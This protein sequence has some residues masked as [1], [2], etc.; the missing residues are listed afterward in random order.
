MNACQLPIETK[1]IT[2]VVLINV[3]GERKQ[4]NYGS[5]K[6]ERSNE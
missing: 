4:E 5:H 6:S 3:L 1:G 2:L